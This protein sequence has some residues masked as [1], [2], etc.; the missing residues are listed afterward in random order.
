MPGNVPG[1]LVKD[2]EY[3]DNLAERKETYNRFW[4]GENLGRPLVSIHAKREKPRKHEQSPGLP[5][6]L[7]TMWLDPEYVIP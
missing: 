5:P 4:Q 2:S 3:V 7:E 1:R 6:D